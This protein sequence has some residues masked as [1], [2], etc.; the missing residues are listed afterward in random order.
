MGWNL[1]KWVCHLLHQNSTNRLSGIDE[2]S[3]DKDESQALKVICGTAN[4]A[5]NMNDEEENENNDGAGNEGNCLMQQNINQD[6]LHSQHFNNNMGNSNR[7]YQEWDSDAPEDEELE[8]IPSDKQD[9]A[10]KPRSYCGRKVHSQ[11]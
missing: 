7:D 3:P 1:T 6:P 9:E 2:L 11:V 5:N 8:Y 4:N 10:P